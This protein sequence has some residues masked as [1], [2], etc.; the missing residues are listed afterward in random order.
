MG[1]RVHALA[2][3]VVHA[4]WGREGGAGGTLCGVCSRLVACG[5]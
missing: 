3:L 4:P 5:A 2:C 1:V